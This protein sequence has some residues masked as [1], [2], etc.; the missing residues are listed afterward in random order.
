VLRC[1]YKMTTTFFG[2]DGCS[3]TSMS[4]A[5]QIHHQSSSSGAGGLPS[6]PPSARSSIDITQSSSF[7]SRREQLPRSN[8]LRKSVQKLNDTSVPVSP[9]ETVVGSPP[10]A[11]PLVDFATILRQ[12]QP[13]LS[14]DENECEIT[15]VTLASFEAL[16]AYMIASNEAGAWESLR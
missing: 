9:P 11:N 2:F 13:V 5:T 3:Y 8:S 7:L 6:P 15:G 4:Y 10:K 12:L 1:T 14:F 16:Q